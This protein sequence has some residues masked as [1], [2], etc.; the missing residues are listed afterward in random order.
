MPVEL[1]LYVASAQA[2]DVRV[3]GQCGEGLPQAVD[4]IRSVIGVGEK[5]AAEGYKKDFPL[6]A[7]LALLASI[8]SLCSRFWVDLG[9]K[10]SAILLG[11]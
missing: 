4:R 11:L 2:K 10:N 7:N 1:S 9:G 8:T 6:L 3:V 5:R